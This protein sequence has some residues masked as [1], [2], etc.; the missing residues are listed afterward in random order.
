MKIL[1]IWS[2]HYEN[3]IIQIEGTLK[4]AEIFKKQIKEVFPEKIF[5]VN[6][7]ERGLNS[8]GESNRKTD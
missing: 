2:L 7:V 8:N 5:Y 4:E 6:I 1:N 3:F